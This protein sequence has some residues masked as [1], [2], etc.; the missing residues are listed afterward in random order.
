MHSNNAQPSAAREPR[1]HVFLEDPKAGLSKYVERR[2]Y[3][4]TKVD[5]IVRIARHDD[6]EQTGEG[7]RS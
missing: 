3:C 5:V 4:Q 2:W 6:T 7:C 1:D